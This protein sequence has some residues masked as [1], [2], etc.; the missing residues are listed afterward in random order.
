MRHSLLVLLSLLAFDTCTSLVVLESIKIDPAYYY[1]S[2]PYK[3]PPNLYVTIEPLSNPDQPRWLQ[4]HLS[5]AQVSSAWLPI[6]SNW[7]VEVPNH[8]VTRD[9]DNISMG[10]LVDYEVRVHVS[11]DSNGTNPEQS[12]YTEFACCCKY[13]KKKASS[14]FFIFNSIPKSTTNSIFFRVYPGQI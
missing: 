8:F 1:G 12:T 7:Q 9:R 13:S 14:L 4:L 6:P 3:A 10:Q 5:T 11:F 2:N